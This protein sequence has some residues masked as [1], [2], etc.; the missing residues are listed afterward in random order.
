MRDLSGLS[1]QRLSN[2]A[3]TLIRVAALEGGRIKVYSRTNLTER[4]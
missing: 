3:C 1:R 2:T 4:T